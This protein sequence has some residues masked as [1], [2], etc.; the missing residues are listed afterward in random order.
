MHIS[1]IQYIHKRYII[2]YFTIHIYMCD[3]II[4]ALL[5]FLNISTIVKNAVLRGYFDN[6][7]VV[8]HGF[9]LLGRCQPLG[10]KAISLK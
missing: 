1:I 9:T 7:A 10:S 6:D 4:D 5:L 3:K 8:F 2:K